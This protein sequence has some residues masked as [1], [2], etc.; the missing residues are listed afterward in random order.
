MQRSQ[1]PTF[2]VCVYALG[3]PCFR[4]LKHLKID[5][6]ISAIQT[7]SLF[8]FSVRLNESPKLRGGHK[9]TWHERNFN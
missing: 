7:R 5:S 8:M 1:Y 2:V 6:E 4:V 9:Q 3:S